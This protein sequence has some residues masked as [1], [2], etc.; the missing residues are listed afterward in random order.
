MQIRHIL[1]KNH[2]ET[3]RSKLN[4]KSLKIPKWYSES[5]YGIRT[6]NTIAKRKRTKALLGWYLGSRIFLIIL[7]IKVDPDH[8]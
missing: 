8:S 1:I 7:S 3:H 4:K 2:I 6:D 5:V